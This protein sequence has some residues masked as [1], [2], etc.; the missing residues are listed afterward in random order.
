MT[1]RSLAR[2]LR[3]S[4]KPQDNHSVQTGGRRRL[5]ARIL[6]GLG[7]RSWAPFGVV[8]AVLLLVGACATP[9]LGPE[10]EVVALP[11][12]AGP[13]EPVDG[14]R[15]DTN[16]PDT[17]VPDGGDAADATP[18]GLRVFVSSS[19]TKATLGGLAGADLVCK[20]LAI[21]AGLGG[22]WAAWLSNNGGAGPHAIDHVTSAGP[23]RLVSGEVVANNK[24]ELMSGTLKHAIDHD[25]KGVAVAPGRAWTGTG[26]SG[27]YLTNDCDKWTNGSDGRVGATD[28][29]DGT[30]TS[31]G[32]DGCGNLRHVYC[33]QL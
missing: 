6:R 20:N 27:Q 15:P 9:D 8:G 10:D 31:L 16:R 33:F 4:G 18:V 21:A 23:W 3:S 26:P 30:W 1:K 25:E 5:S 2:V 11:D 12:R 14:S 32:V 19:V 17:A 24:A 29:V 28:A 13:V 7:I 22:I